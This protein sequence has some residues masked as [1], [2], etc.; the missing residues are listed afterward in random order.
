[1]FRKLQRR[2]CDVLLS[3]L[4]AGVLYT[5]CGVPVEAQNI[6]CATRPVGNNTNACAST[7][8]VQ[9]SFATFTPEQYGGGCTASGATNSTAIQAAINAASANSSGPGTVQFKPCI[10][11]IETGLTSTTGVRLLGDN[12]ATF[13]SF[14]P[15]SDNQIAVRYRNAG[16]IVTGG[17]IENIYF[18]T[19]DTTRTKTAFECEDC[20][21]FLLKNVRI[22]GATTG[23]AAFWGGGTGSMGVRI[24][25]REFIK[26][27]SVQIAADIPFRISKNP[28]SVAQGL[29]SDQGDFRDLR[30]VATP[31]FH[32]ITI[33][34][35]VSI[36]RN[37]WQNL[38]VAGGVD[39]F[40]WV[41][42]TGTVASDG[43]TINGFGCE[44]GDSAA[45][46]NYTIH[47]NTNAHIRAFTLAGNQMWDN[48]RNGPTLRYVRK[49]PIVGSVFY[50]GSGTCFDTDNTVYGLSWVNGLF[51]TCSTAAFGGQEQNNAASMEGGTTLPNWAYYSSS[52]D[53]NALNIGRAITMPSGANQVTVITQ[54][55]PFSPILQWPNTSGTLAAT[56]TSPIA[57]SP[58]TGTISCATCPP[59]PGTSG[60]V[61]YY[62]STTTVASS[63]LLTANSF[64]LGGGAGAAPST[65]TTGTGVVTAVGNAVNTNGGLATQ[66][67]QT[68][69]ITDGSGAGLSLTVVQE[70][71]QIG[72]MVHQLVAVTYPATADGSTAQLNGLA[73]TVPNRAS[74]AQCWMTRQNGGFAIQIQPII[75]TANILMFTAG[76]AAV[77]NANLTAKTISFQCIYP[78]T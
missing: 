38:H 17:S 1:M 25:G 53:A 48:S 19:N 8:F 29:D 28:N 5:A 24:R 76:G 14:S 65:T 10:Y 31:T 21:G 4:V 3:A 2:M 70:G 47:G 40:H 26:I 34:D 36:T 18:Y 77:T 7:A 33:D 52:L 13:L 15:T 64:M 62:N 39:C 11:F 61:P 44:Q 12:L 78:A 43:N 37:T 50:Q 20:S 60:G 30:L 41:N 35:T 63:A 73:V 58:T 51:Q 6:T 74:A 56:A 67:T 9:Q 57:L 46:F 71:F 49:M 59:N 66:Q 72:N 32:G 55:T 45:G 16:S 54:G 27:D 22:G 68:P 23:L 75:N 42:A 69:N